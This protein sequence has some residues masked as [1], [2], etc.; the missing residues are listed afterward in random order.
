MTKPYEAWDSELGQTVKWSRKP[1]DECKLPPR[2][3]RYQLA[4]PWSCI[5]RDIDTGT[6]YDQNG[7]LYI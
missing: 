4:N 1:A 2:P 3:G 6:L 7:N 5:W